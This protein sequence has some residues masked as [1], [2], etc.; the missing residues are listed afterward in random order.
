M[1]TACQP[2]HAALRQG[3]PATDPVV[4]QHVAHC[5]A[6]A[7]LAE[8]GP[9]MA[10]GLDEAAAAVSPELE[11][12]LGAVEASVERERGPVAWL[13]SR[14]TPVRMLLTGVVALAVPLLVALVWRRVDLSVYPLDRLAV[15]LVVM[16]VPAALALW[17][18]LRPL[19]RPG[20]PRWTDGAVLALAVLGVLVGPA[21]T[22]AHHAHPASLLGTGDQ[23][24]PR[25]VA[26]FLTGLVLGIP[27]LLWSLI[28]LRRSGRWGLPLRLSAVAAGALGTVGVFMHCPLV[29]PEHLLAGHATV[30][31]PFIVLGLVAG[32]GFGRRSPDSAP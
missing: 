28:V 26:C 14:P 29:T 4:A 11:A 21:L 20:L 8:G 5:P 22:P 30:L 17:V 32:F 16:L 6:C 15:D 24:V 7:A 3:T 18:V 31:V 13:R 9:T 19:F 27:V 12:L 25:A 2:V 23:F 1:D 10:H